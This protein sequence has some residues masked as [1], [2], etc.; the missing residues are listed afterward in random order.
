M[1]MGARLLE[2][3]QGVVLARHKAV[4]IAERS[5]HAELR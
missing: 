4:S 3:G 1:V 5:E 2:P